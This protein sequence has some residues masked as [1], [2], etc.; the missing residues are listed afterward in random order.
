MNI[1]KPQRQYVVEPRELPV[2]M[3]AREDPP[4]PPD[5]APVEEPALEP[6]EAA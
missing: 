6:A 2:P 3:P 1:G 5:L 4:A